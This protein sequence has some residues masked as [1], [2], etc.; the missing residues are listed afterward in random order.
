LNPWKLEFRMFKIIF[1]SS[2]RQEGMGSE[3][4]VFSEGDKTGSG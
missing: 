2:M 4:K 3:D 1:L